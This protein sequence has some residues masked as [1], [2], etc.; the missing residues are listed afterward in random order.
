MAK[1]LRLRTEA[2]EWARLDGEIVALDLRGERYLSL[3]RTGAALW[4]GLASG[5]TREEL[6]DRLV[7]NF[8][9]DR[10]TAARDLDAFLE[11][12]RSLGLLEP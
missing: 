9:A 10:E 11:N 5:A 12:A 1:T 2:L 6:L 7:E 3:N 8:S 4:A